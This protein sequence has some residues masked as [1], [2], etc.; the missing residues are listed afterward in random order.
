MI[1]LKMRHASVVLCS[2]LAWHTS[3]F[4][5][6][7]AQERAGALLLRRALEATASG[8]CASTA[9]A[10]S[11]RGA[12]DRQAAMG[13]EMYASF[14]A[15]RR[16]EFMGFQ[17]RKNEPRFEVYR[18]HY[19]KTDMIWNVLLDKDNKILQLLPVPKRLSADGKPLDP[20]MKHLD[21]SSV[22]PR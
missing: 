11:A 4:G 12:C 7:E 6:A 9:V 10:T 13:R 21:R 16:I 15:I 19:Q 8:R 1:I 17:G 3:L 5:I 2:A 20:E 22:P 14:G 18:V